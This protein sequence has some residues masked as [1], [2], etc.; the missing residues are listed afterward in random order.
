MSTKERNSNFELLRLVAMLFIV[1]YHFLVCVY[2]ETQGSEV[3]LKA[4]WLP[5]HIAVICFV[6]ISGYFHI[7]PTIRGA[8]KLILPLV[9]YYSIPLLFIG[10]GKIVNDI[11]EIEY[12][13]F[14]FIS[15]SP[16]WFIRVYFCL[17]LISPLLNKWLDNSTFRNKLFILFVLFFIS[18]YEAFMGDESVFGGKNVVFFMF[19]YVLGDILREKQEVL[20][21]LNMV[22]LFLGWLIFNIVLVLLWIRFRETS[23]GE[24]LWYYSFPYSS[25]L[26]IINATWFFIIFSKIRLKSTII[27]YCAQSVFAVYILTEHSLIKPL[28]LLPI[29]TRIYSLIHNPGSLVLTII[30]FAMVVMFVCVLID[31]I[32]RPLFT[33]VLRLTAPIKNQ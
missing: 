21:K 11:G 2:D 32:F 5:L 23:F 26:I 14:F 30:F 15:R 29:L 20:N 6:L 19:L 28:L 24:H 7:K 3:I 12:S 22:I 9:L 33:R 13:P 17:F 27:N 31:F 8:L 10:S 16:Y 1:T 18:V 4:L 25:P